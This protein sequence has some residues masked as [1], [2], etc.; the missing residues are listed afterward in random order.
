MAGNVLKRTLEYVCILA[1]VSALVFFTIH[2]FS[3]VDPVSV[4]VGGKGASPEMIAMAR[5]KYHLD[6]PLWK[7]YL[8]WISG[9]LKGDFGLSYK[10]Q[11]PVLESICARAP[12]TAGLVVGASVI[13]LVLAIPLGVFSAVKQD[14]S[15]D[16]FISMCSLIL[17]AVPPF[18]LSL[19]LVVVLGKTAPDYPITG[20]YTGIGGYLQRLAV[21]CIALA[22][23]KI[24]VTLKVTRQGMIE[25]L[26]SPYVQNLRAKGMPEGVILWKH[27]FRN[28]MIPLISILS[29]QMGAM[30]VGAVL[31]ESVFSL[32]GIGS[33]LIESIKSGDFPVIQAIIM[34][35]VLVFILTGAL[36][37]LMIGLV[38]P[39]LKKR[40]G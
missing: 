8:I 12:V 26:K 11:T 20:G 2:L 37:D 38:D 6:Q 3:P 18:L 27:A 33:Y 35:L 31:V 36:S 25:Q 13:S 14:E 10:Y 21:P 32:S 39:R 40:K 15:A 22:C 24:T 7:Q 1:V 28:T 17:A 29:I 5:Q 23:S 16:W 9:V 34:M 30:I 4:I 19:L